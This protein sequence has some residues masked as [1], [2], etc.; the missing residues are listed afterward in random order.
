MRTV[1]ASL[2]ESVLDQIEDAGVVVRKCPGSQPIYEVI[3]NQPGLSVLNSYWTNSSAMDPVLIPTFGNVMDPY[4]TPAAQVEVLSILG[5]FQAQTDSALTGSFPLSI[6]FAVPLAGFQYNQSQTVL[7]AVQEE[8]QQLIRFG[9]ECRALATLPS[10]HI[11]CDLSIIFANAI[12]TIR[13]Y[14]H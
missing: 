1:D 5:S 13:M 12:L 11:I 14:R 7:I 8:L 9:R 4:I 6:S 3:D 10:G 2:S